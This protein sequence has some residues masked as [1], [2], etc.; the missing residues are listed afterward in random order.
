MAPPANVP[1]VVLAARNHLAQQLQH[2]ADSIEIVS[3][4]RVDWPNSCLG[5][6]RPGEVCAQVITPGYRAA[7][8]TTVG[9]PRATYE[10]HTDLTSNFRAPP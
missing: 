9:G 10:Y 3:Y 2:P 1:A 8:A 4:T 5:Y 7:F 6:E